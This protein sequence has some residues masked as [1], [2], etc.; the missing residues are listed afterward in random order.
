V[1]TGL[2]WLPSRCRGRIRSTRCLLV[3]PVV[4]LEVEGEEEQE[5]GAVHYDSADNDGIR[6]VART[7][8]IAIRQV[9]D[10]P[11]G[12]NGYAQ[13]HLNDLDGRDELVIAQPN[14][15]SRPVVIPVH[16]RVN[17]GVD[18]R[19]VPTTI[20]TN[21]HRRPSEGKHTKVVVPMQEG[22]L[23]A[24]DE[25]KRCIDQLDVLGKSKY[26]DP[27]HGRPRPPRQ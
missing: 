20:K 12:G 17:S 21:N 23:L 18:D 5:I 16:D 27:K 24:A 8:R 11:N 9:Q 26:P 14:T 2:G 7:G 3:F 22:D 1:S 13:N 4:A 19:K 6:R 25:Q 10:S 15:T